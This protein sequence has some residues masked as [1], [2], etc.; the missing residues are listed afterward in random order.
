MDEYF[1]EIIVGILEKYTNKSFMY[2]L[3]RIISISL[4]QISTPAR[5]K[6][7]ISQLNKS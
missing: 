5:W 6:Y 4:T 1:V 2:S 7:S 3:L